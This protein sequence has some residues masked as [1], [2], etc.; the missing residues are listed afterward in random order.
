MW[1]DD[2]VHFCAGGDEQKAVNIATHP[3]V[4]LTT[5]CDRWDGGLD[6]VVEVDAGGYTRLLPD[7][8]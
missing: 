5:G 8:A 4:A 3:H 2:A 1:H 6:V 7:R